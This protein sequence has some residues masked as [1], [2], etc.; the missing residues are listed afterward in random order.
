[1]VARGGSRPRKPPTEFRPSFAGAYS[2]LQ[3]AH[4][5]KW[6]SGRIRENDRSPAATATQG[7]DLRKDTKLFTQ[8]LTVPL[9][10][11]L[12]TAPWLTAF[13]CGG[14]VRRPPC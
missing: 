10:R 14:A 4:V 2:G 6:T 1:M 8:A 7:E 11:R 13:T 3:F 5:M 12:P 9:S